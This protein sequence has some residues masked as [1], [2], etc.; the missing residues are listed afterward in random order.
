MLD[1]YENLEKEHTNKLEEVKVLQGKV[2]KLT[3]KIKGLDNKCKD[4]TPRY[5][6][7]DCELAELGITL[8]GKTSSRA[9]IQALINKLKESEGN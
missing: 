1:G 2:Q 5:A 8:D 7:L 6:R 3:A 4:T 9:C